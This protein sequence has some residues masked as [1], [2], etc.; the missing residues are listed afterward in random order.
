M[1]NFKELASIK[2]IQE[3]SRNNIYLDVPKLI[4][5]KGF[6]IAIIGENGAGKSTLLKIM[7]GVRTP[8][9]GSVTYFTDN[10]PVEKVK[11]D[12][13][14]VSADNFFLEK[15]TIKDFIKANSIMYKN[16]SS[17]KFT[18]LCSYF[19]INDMNQKINDLSDGMK[20]KIALAAAFS[21]DTKLLILDEPASSLD[22]LTRESLCTMMSGYI[23]EGDGER[24]IIFSTH[25]IP[26]TESITDYAILMEGGTIIEQGFVED[27]K[28]KYTLIKGTT[29]AGMK[30][31]AYTIG[32]ETSSNGFTGICATDTLPNILHLGIKTERPT[33][34]QI[35]VAIIKDAKNPLT[36]IIKRRANND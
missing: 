14:Y 18:E 21:R 32:Y 16:F 31:E 1:D 23:A 4:L 17:D 36:S 33:L 3:R 30:S 5:P 35:S 2:Y 34:T 19:D 8:Q 13:G 26:D 24:S 27:L 11:E 9:S 7:A 29:G 12:I 25:N 10:Y 22:P 15:W 28:D 20:M 6:C